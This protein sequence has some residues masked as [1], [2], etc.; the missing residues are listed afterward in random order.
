MNST[1][2]GIILLMASAVTGQRHELP[3]DFSLQDTLPVM[4]AHQIAPLAYL[5]AVNCGMDPQEPALV[6]LLQTYCSH[7]LQNERQMFQI[8]RIYRCF[9][10]NGIDFL[11][12]K[13]CAMKARYP[14]PD[15]RSMGDA[16]ILIRMDQYEKIS[17]LM[18]SLGFSRGKETDHELVWEAKG[19]YVELHRWL[20]PSYN[21]AY[22][23]YFGDGWHRAR[24]ADGTRYEMAPEDE[25]IFL[26]THFA[27]HY[28]DG[29]IGCR[30]VLDLYV[31]HRTF[32]NLDQQ[33]IHAELRKLKLL[34]F[35]ENIRRLLG[36]WFENQASDPVTDHITDYVFAGGYWGR[37]QNYI[38]SGEAKQSKTTAAA[39]T[40][41]LRAWLRALFPH[42]RDLGMLY[43]VVNRHLWLTPVFWV[44]HWIDV[45]LNRRGN[46]TKRVKNI[47]LVS[48]KN[49]T[50][51][52][53]S[54]R[55]VGLDF[56]GDA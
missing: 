33:Y 24:P 29:G 39:H 41:Q 37:K 18:E 42:P 51:F 53:Q 13:G 32:P 52:R 17:P 25:L 28:R 31:F 34:T 55:Y 9:Q 3:D 12:L 1:Q 6:E 19:L 26:L 15:L 56:D 48:C 35:Y 54:L 8:S 38:L 49:V 4:A 46:L 11:P 47:R 44:W 50:D 14:R 23:S 2:R 10:E 40:V 7:M 27:K 5:G 43:P 20:I 21:K 16:D 22:F 30:H 45:A 36:C